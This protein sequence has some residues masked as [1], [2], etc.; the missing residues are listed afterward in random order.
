MPAAAVT[1]RGTAA[2]V[3]AFSSRLRGSS[4]QDK[5][6]DSRCVGGDGTK[7]DHS[8]PVGLLPTALICVI[9]LLLPS[10]TWPRFSAKHTGT[11]YS[12]LS[13]LCWDT[14]HHHFTGA[15]EQDYISK[16]RQ[17]ATAE[18]GAA[19]AAAPDPPPQQQ[20][21]PPLVTR[22]AEQRAKRAA[23]GVGNSDLTNQLLN[24]MTQPQ[25]QQQPQQPPRPRRRRRVRRSP[26]P[27]TL[28]PPQQQQ[29]PPQPSQQQQQPGPK[30]AA[31]PPSQ[32]DFV[33]PPGIIC[34]QTGS[35]ICGNGELIV[36]GG[37]VA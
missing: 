29:P 9:A 31:V 21:Q 26:Q 32:P 33:C 5:G 30:A 10:P 20:Q 1:T 14:P 18:A 16:L 15:R 19:A 35:K 13:F 12:R 11:S 22:A 23:A 36:T 27:Q 25:Q 2:A 17:T 28:G 8:S 24:S 6:A 3:V 34:A 4:A 7:S 37:G